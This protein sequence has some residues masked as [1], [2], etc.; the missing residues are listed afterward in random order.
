LGFKQVCG[1]SAA[2]NV[3]EVD[4]WKMNVLPQLVKD[5][6]NRDIYNTD[7]FGLFYRLTPNKT[8]SVKGQ[9]CHGGKLRKDRLT[10]LVGANADGSDKLKPLVIGKSRNPR[11]FK[12]VKNFPY[13][14]ES[15]RKSWMT[16]SQFVTWVRKID[17]RMKKDVLR[18][19]LLFGDNCPAHPKE[20]DGLTNVRVEF[21]PPNSTS[22]IQPMDQGVIDCTNVKYR[23]R[24]VRRCLHQMEHGYIPS[25]G[26]CRPITVLDAMHMLASSWE[27]VTSTTR[28]NC[29]RKAGFVPG[30]AVDE[31]PPS[32]TNVEND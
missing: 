18:H 28:A 20:I 27:D 29:F 16:G 8:M 24:V 11:C 3:E 31:E 9:Q 14:Y 22:V 26:E 5:Y 12:N 21:S 13:L 25:C 15:Q 7:E 19:V 1:E 23:T 4:S 10:V 17:E 30:E 6:S 2:D 32:L